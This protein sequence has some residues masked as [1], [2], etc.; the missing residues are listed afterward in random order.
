MADSG[1]LLSVFP[2]DSQGCSPVSVANTEPVYLAEYNI[3]LSA[4]SQ[5]GSQFSRPRKPSE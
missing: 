2:V 3:L 1:Q 5:C 4:F